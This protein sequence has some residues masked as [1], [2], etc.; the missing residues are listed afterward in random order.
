MDA[1]PSNWTLRSGRS[2][3]WAAAF[4]FGREDRKKVDASSIRGPGMDRTSA[5]SL[6]VVGYG[7]LNT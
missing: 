7:R 1:K 4:I 6:R 2:D 5:H 3:P